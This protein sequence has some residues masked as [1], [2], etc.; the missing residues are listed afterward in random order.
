MRRP[1]KRWKMSDRERRTEKLSVKLITQEI[2]NL[3]NL[4]LI[5]KYIETYTDSVIR[6][7]I[8]LHTM[9]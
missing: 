7:I 8:R 3:P 1:S 4:K 6:R 9:L 2:H 5:K